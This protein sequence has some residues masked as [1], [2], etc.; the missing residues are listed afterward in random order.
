MLSRYATSAP[1]F[2]IYGKPSAPCQTNHRQA[3][4]V[5]G[6]EGIRVSHAVNRPRVLVVDS[7]D[8]GLSG[9]IEL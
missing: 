4:K 9:I 6:G 1:L 2:P 8:F 7:T 5:G 3:R